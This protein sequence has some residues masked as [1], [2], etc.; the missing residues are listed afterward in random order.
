MVQLGLFYRSISSFYSEPVPNLEQVL[1]FFGQPTDSE[2]REMV[3]HWLQNSTGIK[4]ATS[5]FKGRGITMN[6]VPAI[7]SSCLQAV[8]EKKLT[9]GN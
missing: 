1:F 7:V 5:G 2:P 6:T 3:L 9:K 4:L 8:R